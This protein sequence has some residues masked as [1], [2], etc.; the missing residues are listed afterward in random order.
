MK[1]CLSWLKEYVPVELDAGKLADALTMAGLEVDSVADRYDYLH[2]VVVGRIE[3]CVPHPK[4]DRLKLCRVDVGSATLSVVCGAPNVR[5]GMVSGCALPGTTLPNVVVVEKGAIR[6]EMS[7]AMLCSDMELGLGPDHSG[8]VELSTK[9]TLGT[10]LNKALSLSDM[11]LEI[12]LTPNRPDCLS[13]MGIAREVAAIQGSTVTYPDMASEQPSDEILKLASVEIKDPDLCARYAARLVFDVSVGPSPF[14][15]QDRLMS[16]GLKPINNVVDITNF[17]MMETGQ[18]LHAFDFDNLQENRIVVRAAEKGEVFTTLDNKERHLTSGTLMI[19]DGQKPVALAGVMGGLNSEVEPTTTRVLIESAVFN[20]GSIRKTAKKIGLNTDASH[21]FERGVDPKGSLRAANRAAQLIVDI[22]GARSVDGFIDENPV[23][24]KDRIIPLD[25]AAAN[26]RLG[27]SLSRDEMARYLERVEFSVEA[28]SE[29]LLNVI[30]PSYRVDVTLFEDLTE[31][32]ARLYG[33]NNIQTT[34]PVIPAEV[35]PLSRSLAVRH[36]IKQNLIAVGFME[37]VNYSF[38]SRVSCDHLNLAEDDPRRQMVE[39]LNPIS[40]DQSV[41]RT[42]LVP[43]LLETMGRNLSVQ[44]RDLKFF[45]LGKIFIGQ[46]REDIQPEEVEMLTGLWT[47]SRVGDLWY[48][49]EEPCDFYDLKGV[50]EALFRALGINSATFSALAPDSCRYTRPGHSARIMMGEE[51]VGIMGEVHGRT[52]KNY[53]L[54]QA[55]FLFELDVS[56]LSHHVCEKKSAQPIPKFPATSRDVTLIVDRGVESWSIL[57]SVALAQEMLV[58]DIHLFDVYQGN[59]IPDGK[60][61]VSF[62]ITYR[63]PQK[64]LVDE[65]INPIHREISQRLITQFNA[66]LPV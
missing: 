36:Q 57:K 39:I 28:V 12:D 50:V 21:R 5:A 34:F 31:E 62:R 59:P 45:E 15:L 37:A 58:E 22:C 41:M 25:V 16:V 6:G 56:K 49:K 11:V 9:L 53:D 63:S 4:A 38:I 17:V 35:I 7:E 2:S 61:S 48:A 29:T 52:L 64:T 23:P 51:A 54:K 43:G 30:P 40:E 1:V 24:A 42:S 65:V 26:R 8:I 10:P 47:G 14:W 32:I 33:Y 66:T 13:I 19:C 20:P 55:A 60:K 44:N 3:T 27:T 46:G 18:P